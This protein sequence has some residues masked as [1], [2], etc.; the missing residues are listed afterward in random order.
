MSA[1]AGLG[2]RRAAKKGGNIK[3]NMERNDKGKEE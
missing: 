1:G 3:K 2:A